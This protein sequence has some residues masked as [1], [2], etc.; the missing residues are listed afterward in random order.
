MPGMKEPNEDA[1]GGARGLSEGARGDGTRCQ[2]RGGRY[3]VR[4]ASNQQA[5]RETVVVG[6]LAVA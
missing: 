3:E 2:V 1:R 4:D 6:D 5:A